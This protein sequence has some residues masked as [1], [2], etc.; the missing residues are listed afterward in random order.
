MRNNYSSK[1]YVQVELKL[2]LEN[3]IQIR[4]FSQYIGPRLL[5]GLMIR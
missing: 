5:R 3:K 4:P 1:F 2:F